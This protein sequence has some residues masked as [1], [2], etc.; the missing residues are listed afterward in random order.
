VQGLATVTQ[1]QV[2]RKLGELNAAEMKLVEEGVKQ[3]L[4]LD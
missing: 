1:Q 3:W 4:G 2:L